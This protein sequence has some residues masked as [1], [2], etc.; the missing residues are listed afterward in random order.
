VVMSYLR[1]LNINI[2]NAITLNITA[3]NAKIPE[4]ETAKCPLLITVAAAIVIM[5]NNSEKVYCRRRND[6]YIKS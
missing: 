1:I 2:I 6:Y 4:G 3:I 5:E